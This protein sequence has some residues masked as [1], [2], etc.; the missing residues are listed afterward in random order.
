MAT[1][2]ENIATKGT[3]IR[4]CEL[5]VIEEK[6]V[7]VMK[8]IQGSLEAKNN[9]KCNCIN[10]Q[11]S[12]LQATAV[13]FLQALGFSFYRPRQV[14]PQNGDN[15]LSNQPKEVRRGANRDQIVNQA[16]LEM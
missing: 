7:C 16:C 10:C 2:K 4:Y 5:V 3:G 12:R 14:K 15:E 13:D 8:I 9:L 11:V 1:Y 6:V